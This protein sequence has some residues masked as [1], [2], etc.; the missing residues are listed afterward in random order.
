MLS[1][2]STTGTTIILM[3]LTLRAGTR[4][5]RKSSN[6]SCQFQEE[7]APTVVTVST[8]S[9]HRSSYP[10]SIPTPSHPSRDRKHTEFT[11]PLAPVP[12][13]FS[14]LIHPKISA[15]SPKPMAGSRLTQCPQDPSS[16]KPNLTTQRYM[17][18]SLQ[19]LAPRCIG[20]P[21]L[22][23]PAVCSRSLPQVSTIVMI[24]MGDFRPVAH[25]LKRI[26]AHTNPSLP[27]PRH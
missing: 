13:I 17:Q 9:I 6:G 7:S 18:N 4:Q 19:V 3:K 5:S 22:V 27:C 16:S 26:M 23:A 2:A 21:C 14:M 24:P 8:H 15:T 20:S 25:Y 12:G 1:P 11:P 10:P